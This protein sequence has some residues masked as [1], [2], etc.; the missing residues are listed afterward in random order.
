MFSGTLKIHQD[1]IN[2]ILCRIGHLFQNIQHPLLLLILPHN[3]CDNP[4]IPILISKQPMVRHRCVMNCLPII[5]IQNVNNTLH[6]A[7]TSRV[8]KLSSSSSDETFSQAFSVLCF[9]LVYTSLPVRPT[10]DSSVYCS[11]GVQEGTGSILGFAPGH[12]CLEHA[13]L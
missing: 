12:L 1:S 5:R 7:A 3:H 11:S 4:Q 6:H 2:S 10:E 8:S 9:G 13:A